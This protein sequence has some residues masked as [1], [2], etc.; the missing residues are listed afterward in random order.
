MHIWAHSREVYLWCSVPLNLSCAEVLHIA[1]QAIISLSTG[2]AGFPPFSRQWFI[3]VDR[4]T[5]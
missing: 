3:A 5:L 1:T 4:H 2:S